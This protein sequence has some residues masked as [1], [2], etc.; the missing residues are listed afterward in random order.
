MVVE[1]TGPAEETPAPLWIDQRLTQSR[2]GTE[3][4]LLESLALEA[5]A[6]SLA[7]FLHPKPGILFCSAKVR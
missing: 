6:S 3:T 1:T 5:P 7:F 2:A 4:C